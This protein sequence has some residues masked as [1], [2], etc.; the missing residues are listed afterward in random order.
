MSN[1]VIYPIEVIARD[2][3]GTSVTLSRVAGGGNPFMLDGSSYPTVLWSLK[4]DHRVF[5]PGERAFAWG[6]HGP[7]EKGPYELLRVTKFYISETGD[8]LNAL[9][10]DFTS[11]WR[12]QHFEELDPSSFP[13]GEL[14]PHTI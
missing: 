2:S 7:D 4:G 8:P 10:R 5:H 12:E 14:L 9:K 6:H 11:R 3:H 1:R 13:I